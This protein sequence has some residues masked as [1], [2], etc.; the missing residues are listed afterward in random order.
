VAIQRSSATL[1]ALSRFYKNWSVAKKKCFSKYVKKYTEGKKAIDAELEQ[2]K[3]HC[4][5]IRVLAHT[6]IKKVPVGQKKAHLMEIQVSLCSCIAVMHIGVA[7]E[8]HALLLTCRIAAGDVLVEL[9]SGM[10]R[11]CMHG[12]ASCCVADNRGFVCLRNA[13]RSNAACS[14]SRET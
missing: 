7:E 2:L 8:G 6:Q 13:A 14:V 3:K 1:C 12:L 9:M 5:V 10:L 11:A 4:C